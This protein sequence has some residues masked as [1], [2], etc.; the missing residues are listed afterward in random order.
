MFVFSLW[1]RVRVSFNSMKQYVNNKLVGKTVI[2][3]VLPFS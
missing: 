2:L 1:V 3:N